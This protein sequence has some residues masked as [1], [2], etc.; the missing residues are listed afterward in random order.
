MTTNISRKNNQSTIVSYKGFELMTKAH[1]F[2]PIAKEFSARTDLT[3]R[4]MRV[5]IFIA[6]SCGLS[7]KEAKFCWYSH[8]Q[9]AEEIKMARSH[10]SMA[11]KSLVEKR[12]LVEDSDT[13][14]AK[15][16]RVKAYVITAPNEWL[17]EGFI[18]PPAVQSNPVPDKVYCTSTGTMKPFYCTSTGTIDCTSTGTMPLTLNRKENKKRKLIEKKIPPDADFT[19]PQD[20]PPEWLDLDPVHEPD[21]SHYSYSDNSNNYDDNILNTMEVK[22][23]ETDSTQVNA[24]ELAQEQSK[25]SALVNIHQA[26]LQRLTADER[27]EIALRS[28][29]ES[30]L[31]K[32][33]M[34]KYSFF[35]EHQSLAE[36]W[37]EYGREQM[38]TLKINIEQWANELRLIEK[39]EKVP[40]GFLRAM[41]EFVRRDS[42]WCNQAPSI[43]GLRGKSKNGMRKFENIITAMK[44]TKAFKKRQSDILLSKQLAELEESGDDP[45]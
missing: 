16:H 31:R 39:N 2:A 12:M 10:V 34:L 27:R 40:L 15:S 14:R 7:N 33:R 26:G 17:E 32:P 37:A 5:Y 45:F 36:D 25:S 3:R 43:M 35:P 38:P 24:L 29:G 21:G 41:L 4:E 13:R 9:I 19:P 8:T 42:F 20:Q 1:T 23:T 11:I 44:N 22:M 30:A 6:S 18:V 28:D